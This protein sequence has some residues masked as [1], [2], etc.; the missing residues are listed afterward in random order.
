MSEMLNGTDLQVVVFDV[1]GQTYGIEIA[2]VSEIIRVEK[3]TPIPQ[4][5]PYAEGVISLRGS[6]IPV[7]NL[8]MLFN[9]RAVERDDNNRVIIIG[10]GGQK[11]GLMVDSVHEVKKFPAANVKPA[12]AAIGVDQYYLK[13]IILD[14]ERLIVMVNPHKILSQGEMEQLRAIETPPNPPAGR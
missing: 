1:S 8:Q 10:T 12:P 14:D 2:M 4:A 5:P 13:G 9:T 11:F 3:I 6:V 7:I